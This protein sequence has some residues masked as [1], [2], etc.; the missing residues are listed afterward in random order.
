[1]IARKRL[2]ITSCSYYYQYILRRM[3]CRNVHRSNYTHNYTYT[4]SFILCI[5]FHVTSMQTEF[6]KSCPHHTHEWAGLLY[7]LQDMV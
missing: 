4:Y 2:N 3:M 6:C 1:M 5:E 7:A